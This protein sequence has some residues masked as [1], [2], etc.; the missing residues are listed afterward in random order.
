MAAQLEL[1]SKVYS[2]LYFDFENVAGRETLCC[3]S[4]CSKTFRPL[5]NHLGVLIANAES[6]Q[7]GML[8]RSV[9]KSIS[10]YQCSSR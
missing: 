3:V 8:Y 2:W 9:P 4:Q 7:S 5:G 10:H 6:I 1:R